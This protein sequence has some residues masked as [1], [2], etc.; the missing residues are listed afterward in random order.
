ML[1]GSV[2]WRPPACS[3]P[4]DERRPKPRWRHRAQQPVRTGRHRATRSGRQRRAGPTG[5]GRKPCW[6]TGSGTK[7]SKSSAN[8]PNRRKGSCWASPTGGTSSLREWCQLQLAALPPEA[9]KLYRGRVDPVAQ[10]WYEQGIA[11]R[12][13]P[14]AAERRRAGVCQQLWRRRPDGPGRDGVGVGR[15]CRGAVVLGADRAAG[16]KDS[17]PTGPDRPP[18]SVWPGYPDTDL[19]LAAVRARLV[20]VSILEGA[21]DRARAELAAVRPAASRRA[22][23]AGRP[24]GEIRRAAR[25]RCLAESA[26][27]PQPRGRSRLADLRRQSAAEQDRAARWSTSARWRGDLPLRPPLP[28]PT[29]RCEPRTIGEDPREP[30]SFYPVL[31]GNMVLVNDS[32][33]ILAV[34]LDT[35]KPAWGQPRR[36]IRAS[37]PAWRRRRLPSET[38]GAPRFT[39]TVFR[40]QALRP[41]GLARDRPA[42]RRDAAPFSRAIWCAWTWRPR[43][44]C[45][46]RPSRR[47]AGR[48]RARRWPTA[49]ASTWRCAARTSGRRR[50]WP[51]STP[52]RAGCAGGGSSAAPRRPPAA[53][54]PNARTTC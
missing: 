39:M 45:C 1:C 10:K 43:A 15:L 34:R 8:W 31:V 38:L 23:H 41:D 48:S 52:R 17:R 33:R 44:G 4:A 7:P 42:A 36:S 54:C 25:T 29:G 53:S 50:S 3:C 28:P 24:G 2:L 26:S 18:A 40:E 21:A 14:A 51:V 16:N 5:A 13:P 46:G 9:L 20:L 32:Q 30:L 49:A 22:G 27:W 47:R 12:E 11:E 19:D 6:P 37:L 35:G